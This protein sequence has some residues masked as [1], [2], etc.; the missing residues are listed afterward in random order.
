MTFGNDV[1]LHFLIR[2]YAIS[3]LFFSSF[4]GLFLSKDKNRVKFNPISQNKCLLKVVGSSF[5]GRGCSAKYWW[6]HGVTM[7]VTHRQ[8]GMVGEW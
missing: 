1:T 3:F 6:W 2:A 8:L 7:V 4:L 5:G